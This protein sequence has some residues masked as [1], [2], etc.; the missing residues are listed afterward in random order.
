MFLEKI[1]VIYKF[2]SLL[3]HKTKMIIFSI[4]GMNEANH[5]HNILRAEL[6]LKISDLFPLTDEQIQA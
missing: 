3:K 2:M 1:L 5:K 6:F 4:N